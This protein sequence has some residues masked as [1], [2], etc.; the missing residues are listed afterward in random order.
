M[1][2]RRII[3][4]RDDIDQGEHAYKTFG[5]IKAFMKDEDYDNAQKCINIIDESKLTYDDVDTI[6][7]YRSEIKNAQIIASDG[8][9]DN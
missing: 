8:S 5:E 7:K 2:T 4:K 6:D 9:E 1:Q 3:P